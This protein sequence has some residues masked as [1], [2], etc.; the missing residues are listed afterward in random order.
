MVLVEIEGNSRKDLQGLGKSL[1]VKLENLICKVGCSERI[2]WRHFWHHE[3]V[4][5]EEE[6]EPVWAAQAVFYKWKAPA[7]KWKEQWV[8]PLLL[9][10]CFEVFRHTSYV[11]MWV[12]AMMS[13]FGEHVSTW[14]SPSAHS[15][16]FG[17]ELCPW[18]S[19]ALPCAFRNF[20]SKLLGPK[21]VRG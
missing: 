4:S 21:T 3:F 10:Y 17:P 2:H 20:L 16:R 7:N 13:Q 8:W 15:L 11:N 1:E 19:S 9:A 6:S 5:R 18:Q 12:M 14:S